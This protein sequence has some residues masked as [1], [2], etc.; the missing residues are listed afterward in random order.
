MD[1]GQVA[2][3]LGIHESQVQR[4]V[5]LLDDGN[6]VPFVTRYRKDQTGALDEEQI[7][8]IQDRVEKLRA[9]MERRQT[10]RKS[11]E[12]QEKLTEELASQIDSVTTLKSLEDIYLP[13]KP[14]KRS[15]ASVAKDRGLE[16]LADKLQAGQPQESVEALAATFVNPELDLP[17]ADD[18]L[19]STKYIIAERFAE[20]VELRDAI[21]RTMWRDCELR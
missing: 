8:K 11:I 20:N 6:T 2:R 15:H 16:P 21:R 3:E 12:L 19:Q 17:T 4:T 5:E 13:F 1:F 10:I 9:L 7:R 14:R 18:V